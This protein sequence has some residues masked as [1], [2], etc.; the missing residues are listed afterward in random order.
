VPALNTDP[1][2]DILNAAKLYPNT[3]P[4]V[5]QLIDALRSALADYEIDELV[6]ALATDH[7][8]LRGMA[9]RGDVVLIPSRGHG[10]CAPI[11]L[12]IARGRDG[13]SPQSVPS[14]MRE[15][16]AHLISC[17]EIAEL[18]LLL[19]DRWDPDLLRESEPDFSAHAARTGS[20]KVLI[21][22]VAWKRQLTAYV[23]P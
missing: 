13:R 16:R 7:S 2:Q 21:P 19:T 17:F 6:D 11:V 3:L 15:V 5:E 1:I 20:R 23:W 22:L 10:V 14:V 8:P 4:R 18:V 9:S 12:A